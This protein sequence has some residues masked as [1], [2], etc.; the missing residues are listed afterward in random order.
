M[1]LLTDDAKLLVQRHIKKTKDCEV[2]Q[3][4]NKIWG[5]SKKWEMGFNVN[6]CHVMEMGKSEKRPSW[7]YMLGELQ[8]AGNGY[9]YSSPKTSTIAASRPIETGICDSFIV[10]NIVEYFT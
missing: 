4:L 6:K 7:T 10:V 3:D 9:S 5:W 1:S 2:L 8:S